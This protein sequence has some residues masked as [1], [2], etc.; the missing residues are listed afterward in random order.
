MYICI[1]IDGMLSEWRFLFYFNM[2]D[3]F[4]S[5]FYSRLSIL[6]RLLS[7][8]LSLCILFRQLLLLLV[9]TTAMMRLIMPCL[10]RTLHR[11]AHSY[12]N[13]LM[14]TYVC[15][16][17]DEREQRTIKYSFSGHFSPMS[18]ARVSPVAI[19]DFL[20]VSSAAKNRSVWLYQC[21]EKVN[22]IKP[23]ASNDLNSN[24]LKRFEGPPINDLQWNIQ[25]VLWK[26]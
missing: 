22:I 3:A 20:V 18:W 12:I 2:V 21:H 23:Y 11:C 13:V 16:I 15:F 4:V 25:R 5:P 19:S 26:F 24:E 8:A 7:C 14:Q 1:Y 17:E 9:A 10:L 6:I